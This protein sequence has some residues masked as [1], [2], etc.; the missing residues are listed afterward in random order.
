MLE[1]GTFTLS[2]K[3][4]VLHTFPTGSFN[5]QGLVKYRQA[6][7]AAVVGKSNWVLY[8]HAGN[9]TALTNDALP[10]L[11]AT[12]CQAQLA[13]CIGIACEVGPLFKDLI[14]SAA[15]GK[16]HIP[17]LLSEHSTDLD[18]FISHLP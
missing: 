14:N 17:L 13:G 4:R 5:R 1:H 15:K 11:I 16:V 9:G 6:V 10:E 12:Y 8:E 18:D 3:G 7:L 2:L